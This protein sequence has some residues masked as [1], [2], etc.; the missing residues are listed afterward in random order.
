MVSALKDENVQG[1]NYSTVDI[2][3]LDVETITLFLNVWHQSPS[4]EAP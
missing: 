4:D 1:R 3:T 2:T